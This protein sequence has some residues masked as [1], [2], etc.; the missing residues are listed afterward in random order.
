MTSKTQ[1]K[2]K[3][4]DLFLTVKEVAGAAGVEAHVVRFYARAGLI[5]PARLAANGYRHFAGLDVKRVRF[6][7]AA[8]SLGFTLAEIREILRRSRQH[9]TPCPLVRDIIARRL[10]EHREHLNRVLALQERMESASERWR[11]LPDGSPDGE[12]ICALIEAVAK[13]TPTPPAG[14]RHLASAHLRKRA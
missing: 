4:R 12:T 2:G 13:D 3:A 9:T 8:Q 14:A 5:R 1:H 10:R 7:R 6:V 11:H